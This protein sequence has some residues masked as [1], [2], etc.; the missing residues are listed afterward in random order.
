MANDVYQAPSYEAYNGASVTANDTEL[1]GESTTI[2][3]ATPSPD[4]TVSLNANGT[5]TF[6]P[7]ADFTGT[8]TTFTYRLT[9]NG[10]APANATATVTINF[11]VVQPITLP[12]KLT[13]FTGN[14]NNNK[15][16]LSWSVDDNETGKY[17]QVQ[18]SA[19][20]KN[21]SHAATVL[22]TTKTGTDNYK[23]EEA[24]PFAEG[25]YYRIQIV[26]KDQSIAYSKIVSLKGQANNNKI[27]VTQNPIKGNNIQVNFSATN[28]AVQTISLYNLS[29]VQVYTKQ[30]RVQ[31]GMNAIHLTM[32]KELA[33]GAYILESR[34]GNERQTL[35][36]TK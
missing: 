3:L 17:F 22:T 12:I 7:N 2:S 14:L 36:L 23:Y 18:R 25:A 10:Y 16:Q 35:K 29:G 34:N 11:N 31:K 8:S 26:N 5:F 27:S 20:G 33:A 4:G 19:D 6:T 30:V 15:V 24:L 9:D 13:A 21:F 32:E 1:D 28:D